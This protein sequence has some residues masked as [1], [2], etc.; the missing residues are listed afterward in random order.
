M[1]DYDVISYIMY[2]LVFLDK[3]KISDEYGQIAVLDT[4]TFFYGLLPWEEIAV[5]IEKGKT[6]IVKLVSVG[7]LTA[8]GNRNIYYELNGQPRRVTVRDLSAE[9]AAELRRKADPYNVSQIGASMPG[10]VLEV[11]IES[12]AR[13]KQGEQLIVTEA[14]K[15][16]TTV[17][18]PF[19]ALVK[20]VFVK[21]G[22]SI[23][24]GDLSLELDRIN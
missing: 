1:D 7:H 2:P 18:S 15:M 10:N 17:Q 4:T 12:G 9:S 8:E 3:E 20:E 22:D 11:M 16:G 6:L 24:A 21:P 19:D 14:M 13:M 5:E 23:E